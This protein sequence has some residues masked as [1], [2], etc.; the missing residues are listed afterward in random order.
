MTRRNHPIIP[1]PRTAEDSPTLPLHP[2]FQPNINPLPHRL[3]HTPQ[4][5]TP[6]NTHPSIRPTPQEPR[7]VRASAHAVI[8]CA[9]APAHDDGEFGHGGA[10]DGGDELGAV[11]GNAGFFG[12]AADHEAG[13]V[14]EEE[15]GD[16]TLGAE[17]DEVGAFEGGGGEEDSVIGEDADG[18]TMDAGEA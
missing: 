3:H 15:K 1:Q 10:S 12:G 14:L 2:L 4:L 7:S 5:L 9:K 16:G 8:A 13:D 18:V 6:H 11:F 17:L